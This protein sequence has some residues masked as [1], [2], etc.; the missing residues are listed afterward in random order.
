MCY[1]NCPNERSDGMCRLR[2]PKCE[3]DDYEDIA[4]ELADRLWDKMQD[5]EIT[6]AQA[7]AKYRRFIR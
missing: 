1:A 7:K 5:G 6:E 4:N 2:Y 3:Q